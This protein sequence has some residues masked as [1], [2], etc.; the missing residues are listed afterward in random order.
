MHVMTIDQ[1]GKSYGEK[2]L[3]KEVTFGIEAG[4]RVGIVGVNGTGKSTFMRTIAGLEPLEEGQVLIGNRVTMQYVPQEPVFD[5]ETA[6][7]DQV[8]GGDAPE[9]VAVRTYTECLEEARRKPDDEAA[10]MRLVRASDDMERLQAWQLES[11]AKTILS[12]LGIRQ[13]DAKMGT[14]SGGQRKRVALASALIHPSDILLLDEPTNHIDN[15]T[16]AWLETL[17]QKRSGALLMIT[18]DRY[19]LDRVAN[20]MM[21]L[22]Q[23]RAFFYEANYTRFLELKADREAREAA[24][25]DK[26]QN[27][28]RQELAWIRRGAKA[29]STKQKAR[30]QRFEALQADGSLAKGD[31][32]DVSTLS[33]RL[34]KKIMEL[35]H[36]GCS[37][38]GQALF[39]DVNYIAVPEDRIGIIGP[40]GSGKSTLLRMIA[41]LREPDAGSI[42]LGP[43]V[44][45]GFFTQ[46]H[47]EMDESMRV[48][49][50]VREGAETV[51]TADG[52]TI[53]AAQMLERFLFSPAMQWTLI[54]KLSG[55]EKRRLQLLRMLL[56][57]PN[58]LLLDEPT[59]DLDV[60]TL[61]V[62]EDYLDDFPGV[63]IA[64]S[65]DR[66]FLDRVAERIWSFE[67]GAIEQHV[68][69][70]SEY[71]EW[72]AK[73]GEGAR[74]EAEQ[75]A[76]PAAD[77]SERLDRKTKLKMSY[78]EE[79]EY[80][81]I[82]D[83]IAEAEANIER[84]Q[85]EMEQAFSDSA[86]L[87]EL[88]KEDSAAQIQLS[89]LMER[90]TYLSEL[91]EQIEAEKQK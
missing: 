86:R 16:V 33:A 17:L 28:L 74:A 26:R 22:D 78:K 66:Y 15:D 13:F 47:E 73:Y 48:I 45:I 5:P 80:E 10:Q 6:V 62:L 44:R 84:I 46:E 77:K 2:T 69:N 4:D 59:N 36:V 23:G 31:Q 21:E 8:L 42:V 18:H 43:T 40:N 19:F 52:Q 56:E 1:L 64:V 27:L 70:Y 90:W 11:E 29:R 58:V 57:A 9:M 82:E 32:V 12:K 85:K 14:L 79:R 60:Q 51:R 87:Q 65:H 61:A 25:E 41:G 72:K 35:E 24:S 39:Q 88:M 83:R 81:Q 91:A 63:V 55:G 53:T 38:N 50:Y 67:N 68:G 7:L 54:G 49:E 3:F 75:A 37:V 20:R 89:D 30:I 76:K 71:M 34:G